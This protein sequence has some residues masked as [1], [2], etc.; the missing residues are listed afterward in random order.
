[1][2]EKLKSAGK[3]LFCGKTFAK[4]VINRHLTTHLKEKAETNEKGQ[5]FLVKVTTPVREEATPYFLSLWVDGEATMRTIDTFLRD[6]WVDCC[7]HLSAFSFPPDKNRRDELLELLEDD[8]LDDVDDTNDDLFDDD[9]DDEDDEDDDY[10]DYDED[11]DYD[12]Y[13]DYDDDFFGDG[14]YDWERDEY[15]NEVPKASKVKDV[16][17][18]D[19]ILTYEYD[20]GST[21]TLN[22][23]TMLELPVKADEDIVLLS[24][25]EPPE[26][27]CDMC[28]KAPAKHICNICVYDDKGAFCDKCAKK[29][30]KTC[31]YF[32]D[33]ADL[34]LANSP[35]AGVCYY[36]GGTIDAERDG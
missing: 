24:R 18:K 10:D 29:H 3:C 8:E 7:G 12:D 22:L 14:N 2:Q 6:I 26:I 5:S 1:M 9:E 28:H 27:L 17:S 19:L 21:T 20:Y 32:E 35:R 13:D 11:D 33:G 31:E 36:T 25:N 34:P 16:L 4:S 30:A 15:D 23:T